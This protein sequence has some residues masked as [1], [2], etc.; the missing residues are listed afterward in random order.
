[1]SWP[2]FFDMVS[3]LRR[4]VEVTVVR[5]RCPMQGVVKLNTDGCS[6]GNL[7]RRGGGGLFRDSEGRFRLG[8]S[9]SFGE[10]TNLHIEMKA[11]LHGVQL[12]LARGYFNLQLESVSLVLVQIIQGKV[13]CPWSLQRGSYRSC[14]KLEVF[15]RMFHIILQ[16]QISLRIHYPN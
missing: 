4:D 7:G 2:N 6:R 3:R 10:L 14:Y 5:W 11:L 12:E 9:C 13:R 16:R 8:F 1:M 15:L